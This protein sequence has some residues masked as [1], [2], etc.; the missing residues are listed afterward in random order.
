MAQAESA[1]A[2]A[3][4]AAPSEA[5]R[6]PSGG[7][8]GGF[9]TLV[10][11]SVG[12]VYGDIGTSPLYAFSASLNTE[13]VGTSPAEI[14]GIVSLILWALILIVTIKYVFIL[15]R[16]DNDGEGGSISLMA[17]VEKVLKKRTWPVLLLGMLSCALFFGDAMI[18][19][20]ISVL[21]ALE[22]LRAVPGV[23]NA[24][25][26][27][28]LPMAVVIF[29]GLFAIQKR[30]TAAMGKWFGPI[31]LVWFATMGILGLLSMLRQ[32]EVLMAFNP[33]F[34]INF[35]LTHGGA[36][37]VVLGAVFLAVTGA[38]ALYADMGHFGRKPIQFTWVAL[39]LPCLALNYLGQG[40]LILEAGQKME[41]TFFMVAPEWFRLPLVILAT[42]ATVIASQAVITGA[43]SATQQAIQLGLLPRMRIE[44]TS[45]TR[46]GQIYMPQVNT[47]LLVGVLVFALVFQS[48]KN[49]E[50]AY[51][52][53]ITGVMLCSTVLA[54]IA[55]RRLWGW[56]M[57][58]TVAVVGPMFLLEAVFLAS[59]LLKIA[60]GGYAPLLLAVAVVV[61]MWTWNRG[62][63]LLSIRTRRDSAPMA[64]LFE[65]FDAHPPT[66]VPGT[67]LFLTADPESAPPALL[68]NLKHNKVLHN[69]I[70]ILT[71]RTDKTP[72]VPEE[73]RL[74]VTELREGVLLVTANFGFMQT[75]DV[76]AAL[77]GLPAFGHPFD[78]LKTSFFLSRRS[79]VSSANSGM[80]PWQDSLFIFLARNATNATEFFQIP[81]ARAVELGNQVVV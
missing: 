2:S 48:S 80:P 47:M 78:L 23:G 75:P 79:I 31:T 67:A 40:A 8:H 53:S 46:A 64:G 60:N 15:M 4:K 27:Y 56:S 41:N 22:G 17:L 35:L 51:G 65:T 57:P 16:M 25:D 58:L 34:A 68:H 63:K 72:H 42:M 52:I 55:M 36:A 69:R 70:I 71:I 5:H 28:I 12:V 59:N 43:Y 54:A 24:I 49:L 7:A 29:I 3:S 39:V 32:P 21:S 11:G 50:A 44:R 6:H 1:S 18:T 13:G 26:P 20:A 9:W 19:P 14:I 10:L 30:G 66:R 38:E 81:P 77:R 76:P 45:E 61:L 33:W 74:E 37:F 73:R 62:S